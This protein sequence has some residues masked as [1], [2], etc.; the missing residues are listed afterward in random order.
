M[1]SESASAIAAIVGGDVEGV[2]GNQHRDQRQHRP[3][4]RDLHDVGGEALAGDPPDLRADELDRDHERRGQKHGPQQAEP[5]LRAG[6]RIG[7]DPRRI[8]V[9]SSS[10]EAWP[11]PLQQRR[12]GLRRGK[13]AFA[14]EAGLE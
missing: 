14:H 1:T 12:R 7:G 10:D 3:S 5:E 11:Q 8:V 2:R 13:G 9:G 6:L 4:R